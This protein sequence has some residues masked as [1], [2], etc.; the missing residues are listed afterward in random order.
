MKVRLGKLGAS[1][2]IMASICGVTSAMAQSSEQST[3]HQN[4]GFEGRA[5]SHFDKATG[6][7]VR[8]G[9]FSFG[10]S[11]N[12]VDPSF[13][14][15]H[16]DAIGLSE[17]RRQAF[18]DKVAKASEAM[19][20]VEHSPGGDKSSF[21]RK[22]EERPIGTSSA[23]TAFDEMLERESKLKR[24]RLKLM[25]DITND[26]SE[27]EFEKYRELREEEQKSILEKFSGLR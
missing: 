6:L 24:I 12:L 25:I 23:L 8:S 13:V 14:L 20:R 21:N 22:L 9:G 16:S 15:R 26:L 17:Q 3:N 2:I 19:T 5:V 7:F 27:S 18:V 11:K 1:L 4:I 10:F